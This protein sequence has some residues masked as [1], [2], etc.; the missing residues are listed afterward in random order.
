MIQEIKSAIINYY[1]HHLWL[2]SYYM[3]LIYLMKILQ[4]K[5]VCIGCQTGFSCYSYII[6]RT[7]L[8]YAMMRS[9]NHIACFNT[10]KYDFHYYR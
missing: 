1:T 5:V 4:S 8:F 10:L 9:Y 7:L 2:A 6:I 3:T